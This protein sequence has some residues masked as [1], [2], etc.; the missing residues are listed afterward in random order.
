[1]PADSRCKRNF[2]IVIEI[3]LK[4]QAPKCEKVP[5]KHFW[6]TEEGLIFF[7]D[8]SGRFPNFLFLNYH[9]G[10]NDYIL[11]SPEY[12]C[13]NGC[14]NDWKLNSGR[15]FAVMITALGAMKFGGRRA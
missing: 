11:N 6:A 2:E 8:V 13:C 3:V 10:R 1:M 14:C 9:C 4:L 15:I 12:F 5:V 7:G